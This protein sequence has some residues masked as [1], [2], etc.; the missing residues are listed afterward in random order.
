MIIK[1][2]LHPTDFSP[3]AGAAFEAACSLAERYG[4]SILVLHVAVPPIAGQ[5]GLLP[6]PQGD[7]AALEERLAQIQPENKTVRV[8][9]RME[10]GMPAAEIVR[11]AGETHPE[12]IVM[13]THGRTGFRRLMMGSVAEE[14]VRKAPCS[15]LAV[16]SPEADA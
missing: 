7:W 14:V 5:S 16:K 12:L 9:H 3:G 4:A 1:N 2:I 13:G 6:P 15:V 8:I 10:L 11:L